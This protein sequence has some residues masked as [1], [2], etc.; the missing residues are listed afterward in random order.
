MGISQHIMMTESIIDAAAQ[1][2]QAESA[3][4]TRR[5]SGNAGP[6]FQHGKC[7]DLNPEARLRMKIKLFENLGCRHNAV[8][9]TELKPHTEGLGQGI[10][11]G[12]NFGA[13]EV[14]Q[15]PG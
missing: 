3:G 6:D 15:R 2:E 7:L 8:D 9:R 13:I 12:A 4:E 5:G 1:D 11:T 10:V 14:L